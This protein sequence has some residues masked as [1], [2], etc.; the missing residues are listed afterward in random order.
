MLV[1]MRK[2]G[3]WSGDR[4]TTGGARHAQQLDEAEG[5]GVEEPAEKEQPAAGMEAAARGGPHRP[6]RQEGR[7]DTD[8]GPLSAAASV[9]EDEYR[10]R[11]QNGEAG[12][13]QS[14]DDDDTGR[15]DEARV[16][17]VGGRE[18]AGRGAGAARDGPGAGDA[19]A[20]EPRRRDRGGE[21]A[22][23]AAHRDRP[24]LSA[25]TR[26]ESSRPRR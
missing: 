24:S 9:V 20:H 8:G 12:Q 2:P 21:Q 10:G 3:S 18:A 11:Q 19:V 13:Q 4:A 14:A 16:T 17:D 22:E 15:R 7:D 6:G 25:R 1:L 23:A 5:G 26:P